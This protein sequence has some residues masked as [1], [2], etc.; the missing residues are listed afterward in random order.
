[1][2]LLTFSRENIVMNM[3][4]PLIHEMFYLR[5]YIYIISSEYINRLK[6]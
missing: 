6:Q 5:I 3:S 2:Y 1:M 4:V